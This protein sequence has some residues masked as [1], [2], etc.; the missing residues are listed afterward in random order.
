[1]RLDDSNFAALYAWLIDPNENEAT[2]PQ[3]SVSPGKYEGVR[4][5]RGSRPSWTAGCAPQPQ[6]PVVNALLKVFFCVPG[7][8]AH[9][10]QSR[11][12]T[13]FCCNISSF[14]AFSV[15]LVWVDY[16]S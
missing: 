11:R 13:T 5:Q 12:K 3:V 2:G 9:N 8:T 14:L 15:S 1:M 6:S 16:L 4:V 10:T 7:I